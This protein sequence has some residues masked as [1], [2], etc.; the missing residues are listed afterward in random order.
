MNS[1]EINIKLNNIS[2]EYPENLLLEQISVEA[3]KGEL[4]AIIGRNGTG[5]STLIRALLGLH[6]L[7]KGNIYLKG[8]NIKDYSTQELSQNISIVTTERINI[9]NYTVFDLV[10]YGRFPY[11]KWMGKLSNSDKIIINEAIH[12]VGLEMLANRYIASLSDGEYQRAMIAR[13]VC[14]NTDIILLDEPTAYLDI[15][16]KYHII[17]LMQ[18]LCIKHKKTILFSTHDLNLA[19]KFS[20]NIW[21]LNNKKI[22]TGAPEDH[23]IKNSFNLLFNSSKIH[24]DANNNEFSY[25]SEKVEK[26]QLTGSK[27]YYKTTQQALNRIGFQITTNQKYPSI[28]IIENNDH[29]I[30]AYKENATK[31]EFYSI[32]SLSLYLQNNFKQYKS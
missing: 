21:L 20:H 8:K 25:L 9:A 6:S 31:F 2:L 32:Y 26:I 12:Q 23:I 29:I 10:A 16:A 17:K 13:C 27:V 28:E 22:Q 11:T 15:P 24:F 5:K 7:A 4:I 3:G 1:Q 14:Q 18:E 19:I 30:W